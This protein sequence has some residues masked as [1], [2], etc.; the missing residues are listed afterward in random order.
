MKTTI[1]T[2][3]FLFALTANTLFAGE[4]K[5]YAVPNTIKTADGTDVKT[6][7]DILVSKLAPAVPKD[8]IFEDPCFQILISI[9]ELAPGT[10]KEPDF[11]ILDFTTSANL[12]SLAPAT[13]AE[14]DFTE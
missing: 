5:H 2:I 8:A 1:H 14:A 4:V 10:P 3:I 12:Q 6:S 11:E 13:P 7:P 9:Q